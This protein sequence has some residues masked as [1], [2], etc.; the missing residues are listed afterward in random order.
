MHATELVAKKY[1]YDEIFSE[2]NLN[3]VG[4]TI[5]RFVRFK[6]IVLLLFILVIMI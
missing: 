3:K 5:I 1:K 6:I 2:Y 4:T